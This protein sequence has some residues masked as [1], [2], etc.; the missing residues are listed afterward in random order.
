MHSTKTLLL[1]YS[2]L[3]TLFISLPSSVA[4]FQLVTKEGP[5]I[6]LPAPDP[7]HAKT[8]YRWGK[9]LPT[10][11]K[12][13]FVLDPTKT[14]SGFENRYG[15]PPANNCDYH[16]QYRVQK[17][18]WPTATYTNYIEIIP[19][20]QYNYDFDS[21]G[22]ANV[23]VNYDSTYVKKHED[24]H[25]RQDHAFLAKH[26]K[27]LVDWAKN[28]IGNWFNSQDDA[29]AALELDFQTNYTTALAS[30]QS[31]WNPLF[32]ASDHENKGRVVR[33]VTPPADPS[34]PWT[35]SLKDED[36]S[37][38]SALDDSI[39][40]YNPSYAL[41]NSPGQDP[42]PCPVPAPLPILGLGVAFRYSRKIRAKTLTTRIKVE[43]HLMDSSINA[44]V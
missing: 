32:K 36:E 33:T 27:L 2:L 42:I 10:S 38:R 44:M 14:K 5:T 21:P 6:N 25:V 19:T 1:R 18:I 12:D 35:L 37:W 7:I 40:L 22:V 29:A 31:S 4:A 15:C 16:F 28:Y 24:V 13:G 11:I 26:F 17:I 43:S 39:T 41:R 30:A 23:K 9:T 8:P 20:G 3:T 34:D